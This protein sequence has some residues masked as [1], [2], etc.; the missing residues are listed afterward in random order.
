[1]SMTLASLGWGTWWIVLLLHRLAPGAVPPQALVT[2]LSIGFAVPGLL[3][4][5]LTLRARR[6]WLLFVAIPM[7]ANAA[8]LVLP[9][10]AAELWE[11]R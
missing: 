5:I 2:A 7:L 9:W 3:V 1:M 8:L 11:P 10:M 4:A 6:S